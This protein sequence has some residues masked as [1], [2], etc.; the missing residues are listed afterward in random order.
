MDTLTLLALSVLPAIA[1]AAGLRDLTTMTIPNWMSAVLIL[2]FFP[3]AYLVGLSPMTVAI[4]VGVATFALF[5]GMG[6]FAMR[7]IGGGDAKLMAT[8]CLWLG[9]SGSGVFALWTGVV[10]GMF[11]LGLIFARTQMRP[12]VS[13]EPAWVGRLLEPKGDL[14]YGVAIAV[15]ILMAFPSSVMLATFASGH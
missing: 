1:I 6:L 8:A 11:C 7:I 5:V 2:A 3:A 9:L 4:H 14:P 13:G 12:Y 10:G 15:G